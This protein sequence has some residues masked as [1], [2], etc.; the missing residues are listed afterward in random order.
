MHNQYIWT[1]MA[2]LPLLPGLLL[3][4]SHIYLTYLKPREERC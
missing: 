1:A 3:V 2:F 4:A